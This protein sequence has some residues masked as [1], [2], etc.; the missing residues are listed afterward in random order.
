MRATL[1]LGLFVA[2][3]L[4]AQTPQPQTPREHIHFPP[5]AIWTQDIS[6]V[7]P[8]SNSAAM[9]SASVGWGTGGAGGTAFQLDFSMH[10]LYTSWAGYGFEPL[11]KNSGYYNT[12]CESGYLFPLPP[13]G[14]AG[15]VE[16]V[17]DYSSCG[18][19]DC[20]LSVVL[21]NTLYESYQ[22]DV[23]GSG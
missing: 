5:G 14:T 8:A 9:T 11:V 2:Q 19:G 18:G 10:L 22:T 7:T 16:G 20:H 12:D 23:D 15:A 6:S 3:A 1:F 17:S 4:F 13:E 21:G